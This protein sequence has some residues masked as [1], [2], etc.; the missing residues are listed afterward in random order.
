MGENPSQIEREIREERSD[1]DR[2][3]RT[4]EDK[5]R[6]MTDWRTHH[7]NHPGLFLGLAFA[8]GMVIGLTTVPRA[9]R[10]IASSW[11]ERDTSHDPVRPMGALS[12][13]ASG[14]RAMAR[15]QVAETWE[16]V[17][18][19]LLR[20]GSAR[21]VDFVSGLVPGFREQFDRQARGSSDY[22]REPYRTP[23]N[24]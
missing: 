10:N 13:S 20:V 14:T 21:L 3:L 19:A 5:T 23:A 18:D 7:R 15:R 9:S 4:L 2:N 1:L 8:A 6:E 22:A 11:P 16:H 17:A 12:T 24:V